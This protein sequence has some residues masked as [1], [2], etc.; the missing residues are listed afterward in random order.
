MAK[1]KIADSLDECLLQEHEGETP[2][3]VP[4]P[5]LE[6]AGRL[7]RLQTYR[8]PEARRRRAKAALRAAWLAQEART[9]ARGWRSWLTLPQVLAGARGAAIALLAAVVLVI[10]LTVTAIAASE[11]GDIGYG[12]R[13]MLERVPAL[14]QSQGQPRA[15]AELTIADRRLAELDTYLQRTGQLA[16]AAVEALLEGNAAAVAAAGN[17]DDIERRQVAVHIAEHAAELTRLADAA[18]DPATQAALQAASSEAAQMAAQ[19]G[20]LAPEPSQPVHLWPTSTVTAMPILRDRPS[21]TPS[22]LARSSQSIATR[23][24]PAPTATERSGPKDTVAPGLRATAQAVMPTASA[25]RQPTTQ[26]GPVTRA[27]GPGARATA[28]AHTA[29]PKTEPTATE[30][31]GGQALETPA[32]GR[33]ATALAQTVTPTVLTPTPLTPTPAQ[34]AD[35]TAEPEMGTP[36]P[37]HRAT[38]LAQTAVPTAAPTTTKTPTG[39]GKP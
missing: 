38:V 28:L 36:A 9:D 21:A 20:N 23:T 17:L 26:P 31:P 32:P 27:P 8:L 15:E 30:T 29:T 22:P 5:L 2:V 12:A 33:R 11:P 24:A 37:G 16:P 10:P 3:A 18:T 14:I 7:R 34:A 13:V 39:G 4:A 19:L 35:G 6:T 1:Q 25:T